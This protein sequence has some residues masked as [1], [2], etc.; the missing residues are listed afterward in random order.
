MVL[1]ERL[2]WRTGNRGTSPS[3]TKIAEK[4]NADSIEIRPRIPSPHC[5]TITMGGYLIK[6]N[7]LRAELEADYSF[8]TDGRTEA[9][10]ALPHKYISH[11]GMGAWDSRLVGRRG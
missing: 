7:D 11:E 10:G 6:E 9:I 4:N 8:Q 2:D 1:W 5:I 3:L